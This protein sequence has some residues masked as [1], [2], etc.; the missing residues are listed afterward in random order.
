MPL[1]YCPLLTA[2]V[3]V[4]SGKVFLYFPF[5]NNWKVCKFWPKICLG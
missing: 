2:E 1:V 5:N 4:F 3:L